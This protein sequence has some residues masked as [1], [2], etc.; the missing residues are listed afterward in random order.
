MPLS[1][2]KRI[3]STVLLVLVCL[4]GALY[5][6]LVTSPGEHFLK[7]IAESRLGGMSGWDVHIRGLET[8]LLSRLVLEEVAVFRIER[9]DTVPLVDIGRMRIAYSLRGLHAR[10]IDVTKIEVDR[11]SVSVRR[12]SAGVLDLPAFD[13]SP[14][15]REDSDGGFSFTVNR[16]I[17]R[18]A[19]LSYHD[20]RTGVDGRLYDVAVEVRHKDRGTYAYSIQTGGGAVSYDTL[21][22]PIEILSLGGTVNSQAAVI[23]SLAVRVPG[24][25]CRGNGTLTLSGE[26]PTIEGD[27]LIS[28][29]LGSI[30]DLAAD[31]V[32]EM[33]KPVGGALESSINVTGS[34]ARPRIA[35]RCG[36]ADARFA[37][38][39]IAEGKFEAA[40]DSDAVAID[41]LTLSLLGGTFGCSGVI[42]TDSLS[43]Y[44]AEASFEGIALE[45]ILRLVHGAHPSYRG[46]IFGTTAV[47]GS[48]RE[49]IPSELHADVRVGSFEY[50]SRPMPDITVAL[51]QRKGEYKVRFTHESVKLESSG[52]FAGERIDGR[53]SA[54]VHDLG[55]LAGLFDVHDLEGR[56][57]IDGSVQGSYRTPEIDADIT[58]GGLAYRHFPVDSLSGGVLFGD[59]TLRLRGWSV[60]G[61]LT[62]V[63]TVHPPFDLAGLTGG[64]T[65]TG[66]VD[67]ALPALAGELTVDL[68]EFGYGETRVDRG[69]LRVVLDGRRVYLPALELHRDSLLVKASAVYDITTGDGSCGVDILCAGKGPAVRAETPSDGTEPARTRP[70]LH[71]HGRLA[72]TFSALSE[73]GFTVRL[74]GRGVDLAPLRSIVPAMPPAAGTVDLD[75]DAGGSVTE[76]RLALRFYAWRPRFRGLGVDS[77]TGV[78]FFDGHSLAL[79]RLDIHDRGHRTRVEATVGITGTEGG[80]Y[81]VERG[82]PFRGRVTGGDIDLELFDPFLAPGTA[83][84][85]TGSFDIIWDGTLAFPHPSGTIRVADGSVRLRGETPEIQAL[86]LTASIRDSIL[87]V[88]S[89]NGFLK[90]T[91]FLARGEFSIGSIDGA[92]GFVGA[93][94][95]TA[96]VELDIAGIEALEGKGSMT[97]DS[98]S[99][100]TRVRG[101]DLSLLQPF[102]PDLKGLAGSVNGELMI[103]GPPRAPGIDGRLTVRGMSFQHARLGQ[104]LSEGTVVVSFSRHDVIVDSLSLRFGEGSITAAGRFTYRG[105]DLERIDFRLAA[106]RLRVAVP[107]TVD[108]LVHSARFTYRTEEQSHILDGDVTLGETRL[109]ANFKPQS[110]LPF[111]RSIERP[112]RELPA[113][114][115]RT[116]LNVRIRESDEIWID[117]NFARIR[118]HP[119]I[120]IVGYPSQT[121][122]TGRLSIVK[123]YV[124]FLDRKFEIGRGVIDFID[125]DRLNPIV[126][127]EART[128][129]KAYQAMEMTRYEITLAIRG[130]LDEASVVLTSEPP[131]ERPDIVSLLALGATRSQLTGT[132]ETKEDSSVRGVLLERAQA[133]TSQRVGSYISRNV[134]G[135]IGLDQISIEGNLFRFDDSWGPEL[136]AAKRLSDR[137]EITYR[138]NIGHLNEHNIRLDYR[139]TRRFSLQGETD[140]L[141]RSGLDIKYG[142]KFK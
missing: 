4:F 103:N 110:I 68:T 67:G 1:R 34:V 2:A 126:D 63:D 13:G 76:P 70:V 116:R 121:N 90:Q 117:N 27:V 122:V 64:F 94:R 53:L 101:I 74:E 71:D 55:P 132:G 23:D 30:A 139:L 28:G 85:G 37:G 80:G 14:G 87:Y 59:G 129:V 92:S 41:R 105:N 26:S 10:R 43:T 8:N 119:E 98:I 19:R 114:L 12:D 56:L 78:V 137:V 107:K 99:L 128:A 44:S 61:S 97:T 91:P 86:N 123:G 131:L 57:W 16:A 130:P 60:Y 66:R 127:F 120:S 11:L 136:L 106:D 24:L 88:Q 108:L 50:R 95:I 65:Y 29:D 38:V 102:V 81:T 142:L 7:G 133:L 52:R 54:E 9:G 31:L 45:S 17:A 35:V 118:A 109:I 49:I 75:V 83:V 113:F 73:R 46:R 112:Q 33:A 82:S 32:P 100:E 93:R 96:N 22:A 84:R 69:R 124:L 42:S 18:D 79:Q 140:Q 40:V 5:I 3:I 138:T 58:G 15:T 20:E 36:V 39:E 89:L 104:P 21:E 6:F 51:K 77:M 135:L 62:P 25:A 115:R 47:S 72:V 111:A 48:V 134:G 141:G 125:P